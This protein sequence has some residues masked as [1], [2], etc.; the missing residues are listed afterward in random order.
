M[1]RV[2]AV[3]VVTHQAAV[4]RLQQFRGATLSV[5]GVKGLDPQC[6]G[7]SHTHA[8]SWNPCNCTCTMAQVI[9]IKNDNKSLTAHEPSRL[10]F[11]SFVKRNQAI[12]DLGEVQSLQEVTDLK[13]LKQQKH[14]TL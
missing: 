5:Q 1:N 2:V 13:R 4:L 14:S 12:Q 10:T 3:A 9:H 8:V 11:S 7:M 6:G